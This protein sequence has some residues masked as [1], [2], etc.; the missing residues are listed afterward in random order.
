MA[1]EAWSVAFGPLEDLARDRSVTDVAVTCDGRVWADR[2]AGMRE[3]RPRLPFRSPQVVRDYAV[4]LCAQ[5]GR[6]LDDARP[7]A[8]A[9]SVEGVRVHAVIAPIV[10]QGA[11]VSIRFPDRSKASLAALC[12]AGMF[13]SSWLPVL[14][15]LARRRATVLVTGGTGAGKTTLLKALLG[16][17]DAGERLVIVEEVRE[18]GGLAHPDTVPLVTREA[19]VE[20]AGAVGLPALVKATLRMRP[21]RVILGE[22]RGEEIAD[23]LRAFNSG[24]HGGMTTMH[25]DGVDRVPSRLVSL[26]LLAGLSPQA[27]AMLAEGAFDV[28]LHVE[29]D[30]RGRRIAQIGRLV[31][32]DRGL[33]GL[34]LASWDGT[35]RPSL[36]PAW[37]GFARRWASPTLRMAARTPRAA[38]SAYAPRPSRAE[39]GGLR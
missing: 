9:S 6:R 13:P 1:G 29:R 24:H 36:A 30:A 15:G 26:G 8:D 3:H 34:P 7:I 27:L 14:A 11:A 22:C 16:E 17:C 12:A 19:N 10:P 39:R 25:A 32:G 21:D 33:A 18:L 20:G 31:S 23:L 5:L 38:P 35:G 4:Q 2:G 28:V 37:D